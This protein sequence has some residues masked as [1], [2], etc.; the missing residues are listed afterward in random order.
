MRTLQSP[1]NG[2]DS[3]VAWGKKFRNQPLS[4]CFQFTEYCI[5]SNIRCIPMYVVSI[6]KGAL[7]ERPL[8]FQLHSLSHDISPS[9]LSLYFHHG[10]IK[11]LVEHKKIDGIF[12]SE[13]QKLQMKKKLDGS[14][15]SYLYLNGGDT[16]QQ[17]LSSST[18]V[19]VTHLV[20]GVVVTNG[21]KL[22]KSHGIKHIFHLVVLSMG[23]FSVNSSATPDNVSDAFRKG[24]LEANRRG[25]TCIGVRFP[26]TSRYEKKYT[27]MDIRKAMMSV[28]ND[29]HLFDGVN[30]IVQCIY[31][32]FPL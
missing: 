17:Q 16:I 6:R 15:S 27:K 21:G 10:D 4:F 30:Q 23:I 22:E 1:P 14:V 8:F 13:N 25:I 2:Y 11:D 3:V 19:N 32:C 26:F 7:K 12:S 20:G 29:P 24:I 5:Y 28:V 18:P 9:N 31:F